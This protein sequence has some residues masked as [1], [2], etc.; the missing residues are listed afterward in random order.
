MRVELRA[1]QVLAACDAY[2]AR[3]DA[4]IQ[5]ERDEMLREAQAK[6]RR[7]FWQ[8]LRGLPPIYLN[9]IEAQKLLE[10][11]G[12]MFVSRWDSPKYCGKAAAERVIA[13]RDL[14]RKAG[15]S[16]WV[17]MTPEDA[18]IFKERNDL[19]NAQPSVRCDD[20]HR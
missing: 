4:R 18:F 17:T 14:C 15:G 13:I 2:L 3:R 6:D 8:R 19:C 7:T 10:D 9:R 20:A 1:A 11:S 12:D 5:R 16:A